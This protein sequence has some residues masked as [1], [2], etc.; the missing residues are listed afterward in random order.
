LCFSN[1]GKVY[2]L[3]VYEIPQASRIAKGRPLVNLIQLDESERITSLLNVE[4]FDADGYVF[5]ATKNGVVKKTPLSDFKLPRKSGKRA[6]KLDLNDELVGT[7][8]TTGSN[9]LML[10][11][12]AGKAVFFNEKDAR[13]LGRD[14]RGVK[15]ITL[16][17]DQ[18]VISLIMPDNNNQILTVSENGFGKTENDQVILISNKGTLVRTKVSEISI[19]G[20]NTQGVRVIKL[21]AN[22]L[23]NGMALTIEDDENPLPEQIKDDL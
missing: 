2:W 9:D 12:D 16:E 4:T 22:E 13:P 8:I 15:G 19:I 17:E 23:L 18:S 21:K 10:V 6:I 1:L 11:S 5:M 20:R 14:T 3:K 7:S